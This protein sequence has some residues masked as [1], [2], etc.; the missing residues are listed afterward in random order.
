MA[1]KGCPGLE[2]LNLARCKMTGSDLVEALSKS[3]KLKSL[4]LSHCSQ[5]TGEHLLEIASQCPQIQTLLLSDLD[6]SGSNLNQLA[7]L[8]LELRHLDIRRIA[9]EVD[10]CK[11]IA[12]CSELRSL[13][14]S[15]SRAPLDLLPRTLRLCSKLEKLDIRDISNAP[16]MS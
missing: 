11:G 9:I 10:H 13:E 8:C 6:L 3:S 1:L 12:K 2:N 4:D 5:V 14:I 15:L 16:T 7:E